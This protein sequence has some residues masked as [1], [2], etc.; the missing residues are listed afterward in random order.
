M[1]AVKPAPL[2]ERRFE[3]PSGRASRA[4]TNAAAGK[5]KRL[6]S[7]ARALLRA[8]DAALRS[9]S[10]L[11]QLLD[12]Q[13]Q[14]GAHQRTGFTQFSHQQIIPKRNQTIAPPLVLGMNTAVTQQYPHAA[15]RLIRADYPVTGKDGHRPLRVPFILDHHPLHLVVSA[16]RTG[17][18]TSRCR[19]GRP[20]ISVP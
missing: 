7:S 18:H 6:C 14:L 8:G 5:A 3:M 9:P 20:G 13:I 19:A 10:D 1:L 16:R 17:P 2:P 12:T 4:N 11:Q 15:G